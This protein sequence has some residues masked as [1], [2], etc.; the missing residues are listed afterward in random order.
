MSN[1]IVVLNAGSSSIKFSLFLEKDGNLELDIR[2]QIEGI[3]TGARFVS[4]TP[5]G[6]VKAENSWPDGVALGHDGAL[7]HLIA[8]LRSEISDD[9]LI[10]I[11]HR[12]VHGGLAYTQPVRV[13]AEVLK[14]LETFVPLAPLHQPHNL[15]PIRRALEQAP[16]LPQVACFD[17]AFHRSQ[18]EVAQMF[19]LPAELREA[20]VMRYGFHGLSYEYIASV[21]PDIS[22]KAAKGRCVVLHLGNGASMCALEAGRS[23]A[24]TMGFTAVEGLP[25]G[26]R[27]GTLDPGVILYL[28]DQRGMDA[29]AIEKLLYTQSGLLGVSGISSDMRTLLASGEPPA[30]LAVDLFLY[31]IR[32]ELGSLAAAL[33]GLDAIVFTGGIGENAP[34]IRSRVCQN[35]AWLG[36]A[37]DEGANDGGRGRIS[38]G[39]SRVEVHVIPTDEELMIARHTRRLLEASQGG[40]Q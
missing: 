16:D 3:Y 14:V 39:V 38:T 7:D 1:A 9:R 40:F 12:V 13:D 26:T 33:G 30:R 35:A 6:A 5:D 21:L 34:I 31:R 25:M 8:H 32:R 28:M 27:S 23:I 20:G 11:G 36:V 17:T 18:P 19:A 24:S 29:R 4:K 10:G 2:G 22:P 15:A 37:T